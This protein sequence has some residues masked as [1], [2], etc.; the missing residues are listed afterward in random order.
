MATQ[1]LECDVEK[2]LNKR[3]QQLGGMSE[4]FVSVNKRCVPDR[5]LTFPG[6]VIIFVECKAPGKRPTDGQQRDHE[7]RREFG[8]DVRVI[9]TLE[10][11]RAFTP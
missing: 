5:I 6:N 7:R 9:S 10:D 1:I 11:A 2:A 4:K 3:V 8:C